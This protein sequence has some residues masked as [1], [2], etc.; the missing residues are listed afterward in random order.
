MSSPKLTK[1]LKYVVV[2]E[3]NV[4]SRQVITDTEILT[5]EYPEPDFII[6][7]LLPEGYS[8]L[9]G[10]PKLGK[11]VLGLQIAEAVA[12]GGEVF[13]K[14]VE[15][16][17]V[18]YLAVEDNERRLQ[19]RMRDNKHNASGCLFFYFTWTHLD[20]GGLDELAQELAKNQYRIVIL[21]TL[22]RMFSAR[23]RQNDSAQMAE[24]GDTLSN[25]AKPATGLVKA[26]IALD[27]HNKGAYMNDVN[28]GNNLGNLSGSISKVGAADTLWNVYRKR[29]NSEMQVEITGRDVDEQDLKLKYHKETKTY[30]IYGEDELKPGTVQ[31]ILYETMIAGLPITATDLSKIVN[32]SRSN[33]VRE[34]N[35]L[36]IKELVIKGEKNGKEQPFIKVSKQIVTGYDALDKA[37]STYFYT[38]KQVRN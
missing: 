10:L 8:I 5:K 32:M 14:Q 22:F 36:V 25:L 24:I 26:L 31:A 13:G 1:K 21:D 28:G 6:P 30:E 3:H 27:H 19:R 34:L 38:P 16:G 29:G 4:S 35:E 2:P 15:Q 23:V 11:S 18:L 12:T 17:K 9:A 33:V 37:G 7:D 20:K